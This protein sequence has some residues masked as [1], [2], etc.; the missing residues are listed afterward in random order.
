MPERFGGI[1]PGVR[2]CAASDIDI[3]CTSVLVE[4]R[5]RFQ[6][7]VSKEARWAQTDPTE[8]PELCDGEECVRALGIL[9]IRLTLQSTLNLRCTL[10]GSGKHHGLGLRGQ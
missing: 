8:T 6:V 10:T 5:D 1:L 7:G 9:I 3:S 2:T 4:L